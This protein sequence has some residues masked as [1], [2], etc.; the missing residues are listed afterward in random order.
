MQ[1]LLTLVISLKDSLQ[2]QEK[3]THELSKTNLKWSFLD[4]VDGRILDLKTVPYNP[5]KV[6]RLLGFELTAKEI[7]CYMSHF[8]AW[9]AC[10]KADIPALIFEDDFV[11]GENLEFILEK[12]LSC[13]MSWD[14][15][16]LQALSD[17]QHKI[18]HDFGSFCLVRNRNDPLGATA[19]LINPSSAKQLILNSKEIFEPLDHYLEHV[20]KHGLTVS[21]IKPYPISVADATRLTSTITDRPDRHSIRGNKK[22]IR[23]IARVVDRIFSR[24]PYFPK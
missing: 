16:R 19:Y 7:G 3:V 14:I 4:A 21:A 2:R 23:S 24:N 13:E 10:V 9:E 11:I 17:S 15:I 18:I 20:E 1:S 8:K 12:V 22:I 5:E 6:A